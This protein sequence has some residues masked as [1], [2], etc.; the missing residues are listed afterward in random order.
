MYLTPILWL[1]IGVAALIGVAILWMRA[2]Y[3]LFLYS[4]ALGFPDFALPLGAIVN[5]RLDD[6]LL[7]LF[8]AR[9]ILWRPAP[10]SR[11]Q[12]AIFMWR[13]IFLGV[14]VF[15][16]ALESTQGSPPQAYDAA[17]MAGC[18]FS[19]PASCARESLLRSRCVSIWT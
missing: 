7:L 11:S 15:S 9:M 3:A 5:L 19:W 14:C 16:I 2:E 10:L 8:L 4:F 12:R 1:E 6:V 17:K 13:S 18:D